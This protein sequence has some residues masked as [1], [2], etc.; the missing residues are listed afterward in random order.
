MT[1]IK[2]VYI[3]VP[4]RILI[5]SWESTDQIQCSLNNKGQSGPKW[6]TL[7]VGGWQLTLCKWAGG[8]SAGLHNQQ[9]CNRATELAVQF[10][11]AQLAHKYDTISQCSNPAVAQ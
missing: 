1:N 11:N 3:A 5:S 4:T 9:Q 8:D 6:E 7:I 10:H 2:Y